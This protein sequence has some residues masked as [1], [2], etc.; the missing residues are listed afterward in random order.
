MMTIR[1]SEERRHIQGKDQ[2]TWMTFDWENEKDPL[3]KGFGVLKILNEALLSPGTGF[4]L[5]THQDMVVVTYVQEGMIVYKG[6]LEDSE[7][8]HGKEF[9]TFLSTNAEKQFLINT[10]PLD[11]SRVFQSGFTPQDGVSPK[12]PKKKLFTYAERNGVLK[13][14]A[15]PDGRDSSL[16][17]EQDVQI[18]SSF[19]QKGNHMIHELFP[20]RSAWLHVVKGNI[21]INGTFL[22][23]GDGAGLSDEIT[24]SFTAQDAAE[25]LL[26][27]LGQPISGEKKSIPSN[28]KD[29]GVL[30]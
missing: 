20:G 9:H 28:G 25:I 11:E 21:L 29:M 18:Y 1:R 17:L 10:S 8:L 27:D 12:G 3:Q 4:V 19:I 24:V 14:I 7:T 2:Q 26:F 5:H 23:S 22:H 30:V 16:S 15:S 13:M 6:P